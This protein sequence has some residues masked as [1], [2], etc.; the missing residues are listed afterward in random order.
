MVTTDCLVCLE[1]KITIFVSVEDQKFKMQLFE[2]KLEI[3]LYFRLIKTVAYRK[4]VK[5]SIFQRDTR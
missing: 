5:F 2:Q 4:L 1:P 3:I